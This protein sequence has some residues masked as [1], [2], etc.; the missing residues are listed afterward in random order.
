MQERVTKARKDA[1]FKSQTA[2]AD[3]M[4]VTRAAYSRYELDRKIPTENLPSFVKATGVNEKWLLTGEGEQFGDDAV[5]KTPLEKAEEI[6]KD[7]ENETPLIK[8]IANSL[9]EALREE[10]KKK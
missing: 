7:V 8:N 5:E 3:I 10:R 6:L 2:I 1:G 9:I 4:G